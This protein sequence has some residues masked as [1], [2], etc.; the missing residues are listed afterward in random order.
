MPRLEQLAELQ[1]HEDRVW[2]AAW[3]PTKPILATCSGDK[4]VR[5]WQATN[6]QDPTQWQC[7]GILEGAH[8]RTIRSVAWSPDGRQLATGS[9]DA[10]TG[11]WEKDED[12]NG[13][14]E[15]VA[16]LE[17]HENETK[18]IAWSKS[19]ALLATCSR[20]KSVW[21]WEVEEDNDF[22]CL[23]VLQEH[24]QDVKMVAWHPT[25]ELLASASYDDT[26][27]IWR[28]DDDDWYCSDSLQG[29]DS[30]VWAIDFD[31]S[32]ERI[33]SASADQT[34]KIWQR[35]KP[36]NPQGIVTP[37]RGEAVWKCVATVVGHHDRC[38]YS[39][40]W[41]HAHGLVA[42]AG[43]D[44]TIRV[45]D[46]QDYD[47]EILTEEQIKATNEPGTLYQG[48]VLAATKNAH[49]TSD[50]NS[51]AWYPSEEHGDW[52]ASG[53]D[54]GFVRIWRIIRD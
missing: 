35:Y 2:C 14:Y 1:G 49:G 38:I 5:I 15:C 28:D 52:L 31:P 23:S 18:S 29:H 42:S 34:L 40:S 26:I 3:H 46:I 10:T 13:D 17:G 50:I 47:K 7:T 48:V 21:I 36:G 24:T 25:E 30:T 41:S 33:V 19:G 37:R 6:A 20:D 53:G 39:V 43:A 4:T 8:K 27:K 51:V 9:F 44:N 45:F 22:E 16:T 32:G 54:D 12:G 11:I